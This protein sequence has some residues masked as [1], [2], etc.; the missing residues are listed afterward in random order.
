MERELT[1]RHVFVE[2]RL[3]RRKNDNE[4]LKAFDFMKIHMSV[5]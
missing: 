1:V 4:S 5:D 2:V 3:L